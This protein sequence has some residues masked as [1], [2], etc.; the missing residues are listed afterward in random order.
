M[1]GLKSASDVMKEIKK[2]YGEHSISLGSDIPKFEIIPS[3]SLCL[4]YITD[5][6]GLP[7]NRVVEFAGEPQ[8][9][10]STLAMHAMNSALKLYPD[11]VGV[12]FDLE[13]KI[14]PDWMSNFIKDMDRVYVLNPDHIEQATDMYREFAKTGEVSVVVLDSIGGA[15]TRR[16]TEKSAEI[17]SFGGNSIGVGE[18]ARNAATLGGKFNILTIGINQIRQDM[19]GF[20]RL[21]TPGGVAWKHACSL[22]VQFKRG[23]DKYIEKKSNGEDI[24]VGYDVVVK[25]VKSGV[26]TPYKATQ[27]RF[28]SE[29][30]QSGAFGVDRVDE[31]VRMSRLAEVVERRGGW[32]YHNSLPDGGKIQGEPNLLEHAVK[33]PAFVDE[34][35]RQVRAKIAKGDAIKGASITFDEEYAEQDDNG[36]LARKLKEVEEAASGLQPLQE[37]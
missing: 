30:S 4:D 21:M 18:F 27:Y 20:R 1:A 32:Y 37:S 36:F 34:L 28:Y 35:E 3:G 17:A 26:G 14:T 7:G 16:T 33:T 13:Q 23:S 31:V 9:G 12:F 29:R 22:R 10:K 6:G 11:R 15:P 2:K 25:T 8:S 24:Q 5:I 19:E